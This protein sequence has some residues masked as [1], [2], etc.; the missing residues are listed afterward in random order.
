MAALISLVITPSGLD[1]GDLVGV[2]LAFLLGEGVCFWARFLV[3]L[4]STDDDGEG[5]E[6]YSDGAG[7]DDCS[8]LT[9]LKL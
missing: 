5:G 7:D 3:A 6:P 4:T 1:L 9:M 8:R 2:D